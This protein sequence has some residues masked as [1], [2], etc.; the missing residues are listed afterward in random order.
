MDQAQAQALEAMVRGVGE[1][2]ANALSDRFR[3][4]AAESRIAT[5][6]P[7]LDGKPKERPMWSLRVEA[8]AIRLG[9]Y[10]ERQQAQEQ[11]LASVGLADVSEGAGGRGR[12]L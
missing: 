8:L 6:S 12:R 9:A 2:L 1:T 10:E 7:M 4:Y 11:E 5:R 3:E